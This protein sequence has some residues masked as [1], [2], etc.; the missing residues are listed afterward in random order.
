MLAKDTIILVE[1]LRVQCHVG[2]FANERKLR[3]PVLIEIE[4]RQI[5]PAVKSDDLRSAVNYS[6]IVKVVTQLLEEKTFVLLETMAEAIAKTCF[7]MDGRIGEVSVKLRKPNKIE[8][9]EA[10]GVRRTFVRD[11]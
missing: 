3:Q 1:G 11:H 6:T 10:V 2:A 7:D 5:D 9:C 8:D 4:C